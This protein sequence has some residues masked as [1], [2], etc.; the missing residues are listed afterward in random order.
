MWCSSLGVAASFQLSYS[1]IS[2]HLS[3]HC[4]L[5]AH[6]LAHHFL[7]LCC[8]VLFCLFV[9][10]HWGIPLRHCA[11]GL[12]TVACFSV[13]P[14]LPLTPLETVGGPGKWQFSG[15]SVEV[16]RDLQRPMSNVCLVRWME[17]LY[18]T[19]CIYLN[20]HTEIPWKMKW[21]QNKVVKV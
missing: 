1:I 4:C 19:H 2:Y 10:V 14:L 13:M 12:S 9:S 5:L 6:L 21:N 3:W 8:F 7:C 17:V 11:V 20:V 18:C 15:E 16:T